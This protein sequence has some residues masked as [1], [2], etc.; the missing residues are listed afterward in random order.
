MK[1]PGQKIQRRRK[2]FTPLEDSG[3]KEPNTMVKNKKRSL[4]IVQEKTVFDSSL[5]KKV[6]KKYQRLREIVKRSD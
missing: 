6:N 2:L 3:T 1:H 4:E 5:V